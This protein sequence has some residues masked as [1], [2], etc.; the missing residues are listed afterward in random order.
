MDNELKPCDCTLPMMFT[1]QTVV[2]FFIKTT[3]MCCHC[4]KKVTRL[5]EKGAVKAW[6]RR[7][8]DGT[9]DCKPQEI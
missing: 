7:V 6:N 4:R 1:Y 5:T 2:G 9:S 3:I 8:N